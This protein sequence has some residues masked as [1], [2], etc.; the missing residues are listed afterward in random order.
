[1]EMWEKI[2]SA[3]VED[4]K[5]QLSRTRAET[6]RRQAE[7]LESLDA[8]L[9]D[10][11]TFEQVVA[12]FFEEYMNE[13]AAASILEQ[14]PAASLPESDAPSAQAPQNA[15]SLELQI[16]QTI[17]PSLKIL[18]RARRLIGVSSR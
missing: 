6:L 15:P 18:P 11:N 14:S 12:A 10:V 5:A 1:M 9:H 3:D 17:L 13:G 4:A 7:E 8:Q 2:R 16:R